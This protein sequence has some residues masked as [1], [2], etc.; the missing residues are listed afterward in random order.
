MVIM[1]EHDLVE[2]L[3][4]IRRKRFTIIIEEHDNWQNRSLL[5]DF[6]FEWGENMKNL[7]IIISIIAIVLICL[8]I[9]IYLLIKNSK[10]DEEEIIV[11]EEEPVTIDSIQEKL[12]QIKRNVDLLESILDEVRQEVQEQR[13]VSS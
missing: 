6:H 13:N 2:W 4:L 8:I 1:P 7:L 3:S 10:R 9:T 12:N 5:G 11:I